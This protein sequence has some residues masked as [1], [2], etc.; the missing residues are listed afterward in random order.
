EIIE[1]TEG[2]FAHAFREALGVDVPTPFRRL[3]YAES[4]ERFGVDK[5]D[6]G[7]GME[8][9][10]YGAAFAGTEFKIFANALAEGKRIVGIVDTGGAARSRRDFDARVASAQELGAK[11][12][13]WIAF[14]SD[15]VKASLPKTA[16][17]DGALAA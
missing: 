5:P 17:T 9:A 15:G 16:L 14:G 11:G 3:T 1:L 4:M 2:M 12:L 6:L 8:L 13:A 10:D 7:F